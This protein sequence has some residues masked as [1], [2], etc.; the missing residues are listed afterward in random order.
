MVE[1]CFPIGHKN[2]RQLVTQAIQ[3]NIP[4]QAKDTLSME[5][6]HP[7]CIINQTSVI[8]LWAQVQQQRL[9]LIPIMCIIKECMHHQLPANL[10]WQHHNWILDQAIQFLIITITIRTTWAL[11]PLLVPAISTSNLSSISRLTANSNMRCHRVA[12]DP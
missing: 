7:R 9:L 1:L 2:H 10:A 3:D 11:A 5:Q 12:M 4:V 6:V 8:L